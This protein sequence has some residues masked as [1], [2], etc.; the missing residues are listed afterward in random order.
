[1]QGTAWFAS[2]A[3]FALAMSAT[4]GPNNALVAAP[5]AT[6]TSMTGKPTETPSTC[7]R[8]RRRPKFAAVAA[9]SALFGPGVADIARAKPA[10]EANQATPCIG[11]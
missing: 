4:P 11:G 3:G 10:A 1:M 2:A 8:L 9:T 6:S 7:G 5:S